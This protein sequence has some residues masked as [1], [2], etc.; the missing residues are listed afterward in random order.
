[1]AEKEGRLAIEIQAIEIQVT[2]GYE[3]KA[4][5]PWTLTTYP[6]T[7]QLFVKNLTGQ[8]GT[9]EISPNNTIDDVKHMCQ[10]LWGIPPDQQRLIFAGKQLEDGEYETDE[11]NRILE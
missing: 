10:D 6:E 2:A 8:T 3:L 7:Y 1:M 9:I 11:T 5:E 4:Q